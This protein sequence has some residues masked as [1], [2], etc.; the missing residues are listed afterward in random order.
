MEPVLRAYKFLIFSPSYNPNEGGAVV[1]H[2]LCS[3]LNDSGHEACLYPLFRTFEIGQEYWRSELF[4]FF[5]SRIFAWRRKFVQNPVFNTRLLTSLPADLNSNWI[6]I[7]P[8]I[9][10][11]NPLHASNVVRWFLH[12]PGYHMGR[13]SIGEGEFHVDFNEFFSDAALPGCYKPQESLNVVHYPFDLYNL[14]GAASDE[15]RTA[16]AYCIRKGKGKPL[17]HDLTDSI[18]I[19]GL[20]HAQVAAIF[21]R[22][23]TFISYDTYTAYS[24]LAVLCG[25]ESIVVP[26][27]GVEKL[28]WYKNPE[29]RYGLAYG[30]GDR[31]WAKETAPLL[32]PTLRKSEARSVASVMKFVANVEEY[33]NKR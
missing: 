5:A 32:E 21:K 1:L 7:Y 2:K 13:I 33:F 17:E 4:G 22:V 28:S 18:L 14:T 8:E 11:G 9:V 16:T 10:L 23:K 15:T 31:E 20:E 6:V 24:A 29:M 19:D 25:A 26:D 27:T 30:F 12:R 3:L